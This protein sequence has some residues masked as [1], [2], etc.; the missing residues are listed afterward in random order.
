MGDSTWVLPETWSEDLKDENGEKMSKSEFKKRQKAALVAKQ[1]EEKKAKQAQDAAAKA[2]EKAGQADGASSLQLQDDDADELDPN[3][4]Y[5]RRVRGVASARAAGREPYPHKFEASLRIP[6]FVGKY[7][8]LEPGTQLHEEEVSLAGRVYS[9]RTQGKLI[10]YD[11]KADGEKIQVMA[12]VRNSDQTPEGFVTLHN[13]VKRGDIVG[14]SGY[15]GKSKRGELSIFPR[16]MQ[17]LAPC[18][19]MLPLRR[20]ENPETRFRQ[21]Y[22][23]TIVNPHVRDTFIMRARIIQYVRRYL[24]SRD[25]LEVET[26]MMNMIPGGPQR[27]PS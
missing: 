10:F 2:A 25:F 8:D 14:I 11:L 16:S 5:E 9:K 4:Y 3:L 17:V 27:G 12:D 7:R 20:L 22:L 19:H 21:R 1:R 13:S 15:P 6:D 26:P 24:D 23:D 18:L